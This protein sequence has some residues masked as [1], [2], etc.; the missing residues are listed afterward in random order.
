MI[1]CLLSAANSISNASKVESALAFCAL[2]CRFK[3]VYKMTLM[4]VS[5]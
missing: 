2:Q 4:S 3:E 1:S 5:N